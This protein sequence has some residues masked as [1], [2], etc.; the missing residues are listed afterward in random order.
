MYLAQHDYGSYE[1]TLAFQ[2]LGFYLKSIKNQPKIL[3]DST[4]DFLLVFFKSLKEIVSG[5]YLI[6]TLIIRF[7]YLLSL[8]SCLTYFDIEERDGFEADPLEDSAE[9]ATDRIV[10]GW[11][12]SAREFVEPTLGLEIS[13]L[14]TLVF[15]W[16]ILLRG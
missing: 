6:L 1:T 9:S 13:L 5:T 10:A 15:C 2:L 4:L 16:D 7:P 12:Q 8:N 3:S 11:F 14:L